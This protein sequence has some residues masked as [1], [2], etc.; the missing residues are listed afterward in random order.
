LLK[1]VVRDG[2]WQDLLRATEPIPPI[3]AVVKSI[4]VKPE[5]DQ[6]EP[7]NLGALIYG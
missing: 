7:L 3:D 2:K 6:R 4:A 5:A 1:T